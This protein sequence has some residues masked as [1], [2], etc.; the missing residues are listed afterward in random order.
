MNCIRIYNEMLTNVL[1]SKAVLT[2]H[3]KIAICFGNDDIHTAILRYMCMLYLFFLRRLTSS[4]DDPQIGHYCRKATSKLHKIT[5]QND[6]LFLAYLNKLCFSINPLEAKSLFSRALSLTLYALF[7]DPRCM[8]IKVISLSK[9]STHYYRLINDFALSHKQFVGCLDDSDFIINPF[10]ENGKNGETCTLTLPVEKA[11]N[12]V[13]NKQNTVTEMYLM[14]CSEQFCFVRHHADFCLCD[15]IISTREPISCHFLV[16]PHI[17]L[18]YGMVSN[19]ITF[20][21]VEN[22]A[23]TITKVVQIDWPEIFISVFN[24]SRDFGDQRYSY[25]GRLVLQRYQHHHCQ[26]MRGIDYGMVPNTACFEI[27]RFVSSAFS[28]SYQNF[29]FNHITHIF[30]S[31]AMKY[32][33]FTSSNDNLLSLMCFYLA[34]ATIIVDT[35]TFEIIN[36]TSHII[37]DRILESH[38]DGLSKHDITIPGQDPEIHRHSAFKLCRLS[39]KSLSLGKNCIVHAPALDK[40]TAENQFGN[41]ILFVSCS[42]KIDTCH[43]CPI[44]KMKSNL[45]RSQFVKIKPNL[46]QIVL[47]T[48]CVYWPEI[49]NIVLTQ[50]Q[51]LSIACKRDWIDALAHRSP[52]T[53]SGQTI[54]SQLYDA[55]VT[56]TIKNVGQETAKAEMQS[57]FPIKSKTK[58]FKI[59]AFSVNRVLNAL[60]STTRY[61]LKS[62]LR[63]GNDKFSNRLAPAKFQDAC[64]V[65]MQT[66]RH[67]LTFRG[68]LHNVTFTQSMFGNQFNALSPVNFM[69]S[70]SICNIYLAIVIASLYEAKTDLSVRGITYHS[71]Y[72]CN[73]NTSIDLQGV[74]NQLTVRNT[75][76]HKNDMCNSFVEREEN[77]PGFSITTVASTQSLNSS[78]KEQRFTSKHVISHEQNLAISCQVHRSLTLNYQKLMDSNVA[79]CSQK[80]I[81]LLLKFCDVNHHL[82]TVFTQFETV[83]WRPV[84]FLVKKFVNAFYELVYNAST[85][86]DDANHSLISVPSLLMTQNVTHDLKCLSKVAPGIDNLSKYKNSHFPASDRAAQAF[87]SYVLNIPETFD[88][89]ACDKTIQK[90]IAHKLDQRSRNESFLAHIVPLENSRLKILLLKSILQRC[91]EN[92][93]VETAKI[94]NFFL[95]TYYNH[96]YQ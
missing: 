86:V 42:N 93:C 70:G 87:A 77:F 74:E 63:R 89:G 25:F 82:N 61:K 73:S 95:N 76:L 1:L 9:D 27:M 3:N 30:L 8:K 39:Q 16:Q 43:H 47:M 4:G 33:S 15:P 66:F 24:S 96:D 69:V 75:F 14:T 17:A 67:N 11:R 71:I 22:F 5:H 26:S 68:L 7:H 62:V 56:N 29:Y 65:S 79:I 13:Q 57:V 51:K 28:S 91:N 20:G 49:S 48:V 37:L 88:R 34:H 52:I 94:C 6:H 81:N 35:T 85:S 10:K 12:M 54:S 78:F 36:H 46:R 90:Y 58:D 55:L 50:L 53:T 32:L 2:V 83:H 31:K 44:V 38:L 84:T 59:N 45:R 64:T 18:Q 72:P 23:R 41:A 60:K 40:P 92:N 80:D 19:K 21:V